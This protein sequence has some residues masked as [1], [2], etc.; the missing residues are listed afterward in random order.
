MIAPTDSFTD[1]IHV[2]IGVQNSYEVLRLLQV[3][4]CVQEVDRMI[5]QAD[6]LMVTFLGAGI[7]FLV[8]N[9]CWKHILIYFMYFS[10]LF[11]IYK[12]D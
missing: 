3:G 2:E 10:H 12:I 4:V 11:T 7:Q 5:A 1:L 9:P 8:Q 6:R